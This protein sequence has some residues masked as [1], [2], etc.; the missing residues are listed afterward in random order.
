VGTILPLPVIYYL[1]NS[2]DND[3]DSKF[4]QEKVEKIE[5]HKT[6]IKVTSSYPRRGVLDWMV[7]LGKTRNKN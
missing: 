2:L 3:R 4:P 5:K 1:S 7:D 6:Q